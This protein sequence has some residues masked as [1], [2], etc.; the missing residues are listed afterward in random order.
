MKRLARHI[1]TVA[2]AASLLLCVAACVLWVRSRG[3]FDNLCRAEP[4]TCTNVVSVAG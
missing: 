1:F 4:R 2:A 3:T